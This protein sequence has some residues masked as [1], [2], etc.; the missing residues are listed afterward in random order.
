MQTVYDWT[1][2][3]QITPLFVSE[4]IQ[5]V[6]A[7]QQA[8]VFRRLSGTLE[9]DAPAALRTL[10]LTGGACTIDLGAASNV[11]GYRQLHDGTY[12]ALAGGTRTTFKPSGVGKNAIR[13]VR[14]NGMLEAWA[15]QAG[16]VRFGMQGHRPLELVVDGPG[17]C[18]LIVAGQAQAGAR[19][20]EGWRFQLDGRRLKGAQIVCR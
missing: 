5:R 3:Q 6:Q 9:Y 2:K 4:Y 18:R 19:T 13:L 7:C 11:A 16:S 20:D 14:A 1:L 17:T 8:M 12:L 10:R 15:Q